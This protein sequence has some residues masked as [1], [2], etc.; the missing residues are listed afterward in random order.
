MTTLCL[1]P[2]P[3]P[4]PSA[5][6]GTAGTAG[7]GGIAWITGIAET[8]GTEAEQGRKGGREGGRE[9]ER[10]GSKSG[11]SRRMPS[12]VGGEMGVG[13]SVVRGRGDGLLQVVTHTH[14]HTHTHK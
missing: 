10:E 14:T 11:C 7:I 3:L 2:A 6:A 12:V 4:K 13:W 9:G 1:I 8:G 5:I